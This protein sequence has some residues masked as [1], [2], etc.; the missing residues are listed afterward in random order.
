M[1]KA[2][3]SQWSAVTQP[4]EVTVKIT[5]PVELEA[6]AA[7]C[8]FNMSQGFSDWVQDLLEYERFR[9]EKTIH[10]K[11]DPGFSALSR[12]FLGKGGAR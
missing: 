12:R 9:D 1:P 10:T 7:Q 6:W 4:E 8:A 2:K 11:R 5:L 3:A